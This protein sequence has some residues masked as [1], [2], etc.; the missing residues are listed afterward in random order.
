MAG[1]GA[2][3]CPAGA[4]RGVL[5]AEQHRPARP[6]GAHR[7]AGTTGANRHTTGVPTAAA[8]W[9]GPVFATTT[10]T[11]RRSTRRPAR[12]GQ[13][14]GQVLHR[15]RPG[16]PGADGSGR[17][18]LA[19]AA[20]DEHG[21]PGLG[22]QRDDLAPV[23]ERVAPRRCVGA[24]MDDDVRLRG[25]RPGP[26]DGHRQPED[27][28]LGGRREAGGLG[29]REHPARL[30]AV[31]RVR[32]ADVEQAARVVD[33]DPRRSA[34]PRRGAA[35]TPWAARTGGTTSG[36]APRRGR[37]AASRS[38]RS[39]ISSGVHA[40]G[41]AEI[42]GRSAIST[43]STPG[44]SR[45]ASAPR[46]PAST[47]TRSARAA[48]AR[49]AGPLT[50]TSPRL[51]GAHD[52][53]VSAGGAHA[54]TVPTAKSANSRSSASDSVA[55]VAAAVA[56]SSGRVAALGTS[57]LTAAPARAP[58]AT[59]AAGVADDRTPFD[60]DAQRA[61][62][63]VHHAGRRL[64]AGA[65]V[66]VGVRAHL[67]VVERTEQVVDPRVDAAHGVGVQ[68]AAGDARLVGDHAD[69]HARVAQAAQRLVR[70]GHRLD[71][72]GIA[73]VRHVV[74][75]RAV[76]VE[77]HRL[78]R[79]SGPA[80]RSCP[81][82][83]DQATGPVH[84]RGRRD[85]HARHRHAGDLVRRARTRADPGPGELRGEPRPRQRC[86]RARPCGAPASAAS[87]APVA[88][89]V[90]TRCSGRRPVEAPA[91]R[92]QSRPVQAAHQGVVGVA[93]L[94][95]H[96]RVPARGADR[97]HGAARAADQPVTVGDA[98]REVGCPRGR[99]A[100]TARRNRRRRPAPRGGRPC[101]R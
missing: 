57:T 62:G 65:P 70:V 25:H 7:V 56:T 69:P 54:G 35:A 89:A 76:A 87:A 41:C 14:A 82:D 64:A 28:V 11:A 10:A 101:R 100:G 48:T 3:P 50:S 39:D 42:H 23:I 45:A 32:D 36:S 6:T 68:Q 85:Q 77:E 86:R 97:M 4:A 67:P 75:E 99:R 29:H 5:V 38:T 60:R 21:R 61:G 83:G 52:E 46:G 13:P 2:D 53:D 72:V 79:R 73:V 47:V 49:I 71:E 8:R 58:A 30:G 95:P 63:G 44:S 31:R 51:S 55:A 92:C 34:R 81:A 98:Q 19:R 27:V 43:E 78:D 74:H 93:A 16:A 94:L 17:L 33:P 84:R 22:E 12:P 18:R 1:H 15:A 90:V 96:A 20:G 59:S 26:V 66:G 37:A 40:G 9:A 88:A 24:R 91:R 80:P